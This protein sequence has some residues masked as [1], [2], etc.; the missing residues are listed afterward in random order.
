ML[1]ELAPSFNFYFH[2]TEPQVKLL[3][4]VAALHYDGACRHA[5]TDGILREWERHIEIVK[6]V[7]DYEFTDRWNLKATFRDLDLVAKIT[8]AGNASGPSAFT[9]EERD[10]V[11]SLHWKFRKA[12]QEANR[13]YKVTEIHL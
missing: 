2:L 3:Q 10:E 8:E 7:G 9:D 4:R 12:M 1:F 11:S 6:E 13:L 5:G